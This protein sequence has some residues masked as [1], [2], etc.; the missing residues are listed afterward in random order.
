[1]EN[2][3]AHNDKYL[4]SI[5]ENMGIEL[6]E[7]QVK[8]FNR[9]YD[10]LIETNKVMNLTAITEYK[11]V[12]IKHFADSLLLCKCIDINKFSSIIDVGTGA[13]F[14]GIPLKIIYPH[15]NITL[16]DSLN[17]RVNFLK[18]VV[19]EL[20]LENVLCIHGRAEDFGHNENYREKFDICVSRAV[21]N[22]STLSEYCTPFVNVGGYFV[23]YKSADV[24]EEVNNAKKAIK[25]LNCKIEKVSDVNLP[26]TDDTM[27]KFVL[28]KKEDNTAKK[29]PRKSGVPSKTPLS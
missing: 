24:E 14:P 8:R 28:I 1:M 10:M 12:V 11:D 17:K 22:L 25:I 18:N 26:G 19:E 5:F 2:A 23:S 4:K 13:G 6:S 9:Y 27:R 3:I 20:D 21:A 29:Y 15:L 16:L 7:L